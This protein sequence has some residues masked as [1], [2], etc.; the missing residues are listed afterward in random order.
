[1]TY[2]LFIIILFLQRLPMKKNYRFALTALG[3]LCFSELGFANQGPPPATLAP[4]PIQN[5]CPVV[6]VNHTE[7]DSSEVYL[8]ATALDP[9]GLPC[10]LYPNPS[11]GICSYEYPAADGSNG[12]V[13]NSVT[14]SDLPKATGTGLTP[15][16]LIYLP[17]NSSARAYFS[18]QKPMYL[19]TTYSAAKGLLAINSP[20]ITSLNDPNM[21]TPY[22]DFEF[23]VNKS[24]V[25]SSTNIFIN[26]SFVDY[27]CLPYRLSANSYQGLPVDPT[28]SSSTVFPSGTPAGSTQQSIMKAMMN[29]LNTI[30]TA[31]TWAYLPFYFYPE[32]YTDHSN[33]NM[34]RILAAKN[35]TALPTGRLF[36]GGP[37]TTFFPTDYLT[38]TAAGPVSGETYM[39]SV[40]KYYLST[41]HTPLYAVIT[42][43]SGHMMYEISSDPSTDGNL[44]FKAYTAP[45]IPP[46]TT[47]VSVPIP[48][49]DTSVNLNDIPLAD[50][51]SGAITFT[52]GFD[53]DTP[54]GAELG[55]LLSSL[56]TIGQ[57]PFTNFVTTATT[58]FYNAKDNVPFGYINLPYFANPPGF[59]GGPWFNLYDQ[60]LHLKELGAS[61]TTLPKNPTL[62]QG[63][64][65]DYDDLLS[66]DGTIPGLIIQ[67]QYGN[68]SQIAGEANPYI[69]MVL[70]SL[71]GSTLPDL[72]DTYHYSVIVG[73]A[74]SGATVTFTY[75]GGS[76]PALVGANATPFALY[77]GTPITGGSDDYLH[78]TFTFDGVD[79]V[80]NIN[81]LGQVVTPVTGGTYSSV[82]P[83]FSAADVQYQGNFTF[84]VSGSG[85]GTIGNP[86]IITINFNSSPP[87]WQG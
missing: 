69:V 33:K 47:P 17:I 86:I 59:T 73:P 6:I 32:P 36:N 40:Y 39:E 42:P 85:T 61:A 41:N 45:P 28:I 22:Q 7:L 79:Y 10:F 64:G 16:Y 25:N 62:G 63:Y 3:L 48:A 52:N 23:G 24:G 68:P 65:F 74:P 5:Y 66:M 67:D 56:F 1:M 20:S 27:F 76:T 44:L 12:S 31:S 51:L 30:P 2:N 21:Y 34:I 29:S 77:G 49:D 57:L 46:L 18:I 26:V 37:T 71:S 80:F 75:N 11:T 43:A 87:P 55:K 8:V 35:S 53:N 81:L 19:S 15:S 70:E 84:T 50:F 38:N 58:P 78:A 54:I 13:A 72:T 83:T 4:S 14:L 60:A 9:N 82:Y